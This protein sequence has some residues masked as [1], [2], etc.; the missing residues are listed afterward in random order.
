MSIE[1]E[2]SNLLKDKSVG[3]E[4]AK[5]LQ[6]DRDSLEQTLSIVRKSLIESIGSVTHTEVTT[7]DFFIKHPLSETQRKFVDASLGTFYAQRSVSQQEIIATVPI[8]ESLEPMV[9]IPDLFQKNNLSLS[10]SELPFNRACGE[11]GGKPR[12]FWIRESM[13]ERLV[14]WG[15]ALSKVGLFFNVEDAFRPVG[16]QEGLF[17]RRVGMIMQEHPDWDKN[18]VLLEARSKTAVCPRLASHKG[19][20]AIDLTLRKISD[21]SPLDL[22]NKYPEGGAL[23]AID[24]PF[25]TSEQWKTRQIFANSAVMAGFAIYD[26]EDWHASFNDNLAGVDDGEIVKGFVAKYGPIKDFSSKTGKILEIYEKDE[27]DELFLGEQV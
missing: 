20:A 12:V 6:K 4:L 13:G 23:V 18:S 26:G 22:G 24:C 17:K 9:F 14:K 2:V 7:P 1:L 10:L 8:K 15:E 19:G 25:V 27:Y 16:V 21:G 11:W 5:P 3:I